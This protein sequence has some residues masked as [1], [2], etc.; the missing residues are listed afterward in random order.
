MRKT[1]SYLFSN[2]VINKIFLKQNN[3]TNEKLVVTTHF[4][5]SEFKVYFFRFQTVMVE[6]SIFYFTIGFDVHVLYVR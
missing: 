5:Q 1:V 2:W 3:T 4:I 6:K